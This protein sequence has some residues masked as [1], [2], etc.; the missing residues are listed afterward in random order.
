[1]R[2]MDKSYRPDIAD[3]IEN[4]EANLLFSQAQWGRQQAAA[5]GNEI[6]RVHAARTLDEMQS[7]ALDLAREKA[8]RPLI[9]KLRRDRDWRDLGALKRELIDY[10]IAER[11]KLFQRVVKDMEARKGETTTE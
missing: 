3:E 1:M 10:W 7:I 9:D 6:E 5:I 4:T 11:N 8:I 2:A